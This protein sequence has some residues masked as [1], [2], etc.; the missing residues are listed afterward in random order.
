MHGE[1]LRA[2]QQGPSQRGI[3]GPQRDQGPVQGHPGIGLPPS[4]IEAGVEL[5]GRA[6]IADLRGEVA[7]ELEQLRGAGTSREGGEQG[8]PQGLEALEP[9]RRGHQGVAGGPVVRIEG[10]PCGQVVQAPLQVAQ[11]DP[12]ATARRPLNR[13]QVG[14]DPGRHGPLGVVPPSLVPGAPGDL[15]VGDRRPSAT[16][17]DEHGLPVEGPT[18]GDARPALGQQHLR[19]PGIEEQRPTEAQVGP[20]AVLVGRV[21]HGHQVVAAGQVDRVPGPSPRLHLDRRGHRR[22]S[23]RDATAE[24]GAEHGRRHAHP[25]CS[26]SRGAARRIGRTVAAA[27]TPATASRQ[28]PPT[29]CWSGVKPSPVN[30]LDSTK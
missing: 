7:G 18:A 16:R 12:P 29:A 19:S 10:Q 15:T 17:L 2:G 11:G 8:L 26:H 27:Q 24:H 20:F 6:V 25:V 5:P 23:P 9:G 4:P 28:P 22:G 30:W 21:P 1:G 14:A 13:V 3:V